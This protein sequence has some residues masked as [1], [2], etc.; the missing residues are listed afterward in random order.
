MTQWKLD[1]LCPVSHRM[2]ACL[3]FLEGGGNRLYDLTGNLRGINFGAGA[4]RPRWNMDGTV[5]FDNANTQYINAENASVFNFGT[6]SF[7]VATRFCIQ[8]ADGFANVIMYDWGTGTY[9]WWGMIINGTPAEFKF[10]VDDGVNLRN[11][12]G[13]QNLNDGKPHDAVFSR[14]SGGQMKA[15]I[16]GV[17]KASQTFAPVA[18]ITGNGAGDIFWIGTAGSGDTDNY[19]GEC[20]YFYAWNRVVSEAE[21]IRIHENP[22][23]MILR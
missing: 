18:N 16:D 23:H 12:S 9:T 4:A 6:G 22:R 10:Y 7:S 11:V 15:V 13:G 21:A 8:P 14:S 17:L 20:G 19:K 5:H 2:I 1:P 3:P